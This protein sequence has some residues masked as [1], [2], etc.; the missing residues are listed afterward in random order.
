MKKCYFLLAML[1]A[2]QF[3]L[4]SQ[5]TFQKVIAIQGYGNFT[6]TGVHQNTDGTYL[7]C[8]YDQSSSATPAA[9]VIKLD[10]TAS[11]TL[12]V[13]RF[14]APANMNISLFNVGECVGG[15]YFAMGY[16]NDFNA[17]T[18]ACLLVK[19]D[20]GGAV[21]W[22]KQYAMAAGDF[23][24]SAVTPKARQLPTGEFLISTST[25]NNMGVI[26]TDANGNIIFAKSIR[27]D[28]SESKDP[29]LDA[30]LCNDGGIMAAGKC[31]N[32]PFFVKTD[33]SGNVQWSKRFQMANFYNR[34]YRMLPT[35]DGGFV[36]AGMKFDLM[37]STYSGF[38]MKMD[39][40][41]NVVWYKEAYSA[42]S[43][44]FMDMKMLSSGNLVLLGVDYSTGQP[45]IS[46]ASQNGDI[47]FSKALP[48]VSSFLMDFYAGFEITAADEILLSYTNT[49]ST[50]SSY[51]FKS[52][53]LYFNWC[54]ASNYT[55]TEVTVPYTPSFGSDIFIAPLAISTATL[56]NP[57][58]GTVV[59]TD[60][61][62][63]SGIDNPVAPNAISVF[64]NPFTTA[65][66]V[67]I[68]PLLIDGNTTFVLYDMLGNEVMKSAITSGKTE[69]EKGS[70][71]AGVYMYKVFSAK[72]MIGNGKLILAE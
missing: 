16:V 57:Q 34:V 50:P 65:A 60:Y 38:I 11:Q 24:Y 36:C 2:F 25:W 54:D 55:L 51:L 44:Y 23:V 37:G 59:V 71:A 72:G 10:A 61:C 70:L 39:A 1:F 53:D 4:F 17:A 49:I 69:I 19:M 28:S 48:S 33:A 26:K 68:D 43:F 62:L 3:T 15:G 29:G 31:G 12:W 56:P 21:L 47:Q 41:G 67:E 58:T 18:T 64:P 45:V 9:F 22:N 66:T 27:G 32:D 30:V 6:S 63:N 52:S 20:N 40:N 46:V 42:M 8:G 14:D 13:K 7:M 35:A 5:S